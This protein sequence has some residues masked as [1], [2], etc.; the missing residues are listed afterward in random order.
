MKATILSAL[1]KSSRRIGNEPAT[2]RA[3]HDR[4]YLRS[5]RRSSAAT[6]REKLGSVTFPTTVVAKA[7]IRMT[8]RVAYPNVAALPDGSVDAIQVS[9][10]KMPPSS[11][12]A[13]ADVP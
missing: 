1:V 5:R 4:K 3:H 9:V 2:R 8:G 12:A 10:V 6:S 7:R 11:A 13:S